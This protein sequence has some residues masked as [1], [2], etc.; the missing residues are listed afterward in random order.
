MTTISV[1]VCLFAP[2]SIAFCN[3]F[4]ANLEQQILFF[5]YSANAEYTSS[6]FFH[7]LFAYY[8]SPL[9]N[10]VMYR[11]METDAVEGK[12]VLLRHR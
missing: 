6:L 9:H 12:P 2:V 11:G 1:F 8:L 5:F 3:K 7:W 10:S 4:E